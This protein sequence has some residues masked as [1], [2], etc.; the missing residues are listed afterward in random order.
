M[1]LGHLGVLPADCTYSGK[2]GGPEG[3]LVVL[4]TGRRVGVTGQSL[5]LQGRR[6][7]R[8]GIELPGT[9]TNPAGQHT[10]PAAPTDRR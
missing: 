8:D 6:H 7:L 4:H 9:R 3:F 10:Q 5:V 1:P 2:V